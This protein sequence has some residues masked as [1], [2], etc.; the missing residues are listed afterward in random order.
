M[1][2]MF[3][4]HKILANCGNGGIL[5]SIFIEFLV[6]FRRGD[7]RWNIVQAAASHAFPDAAT[8][9]EAEKARD[10]SDRGL[11]ALEAIKAAAPD[12]AVKE[13]EW[14]KFLTDTTTSMK[15]LN[16][17]MGG[18]NTRHQRAL[19]APYVTKFFEEIHG[20]FKSR[21][22]L[23][24]ENFYNILFPFYKIDEETLAKCEGLL[25]TLDV[26][27]DTALVRCVKESID[28]I[29]RELA[30]H[31]VARKHAASHK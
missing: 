27:K 3:E 2:P 26:E 8:R 11:R 23:F 13:A 9:I 4:S 29:K 31:A 18:F 6:V 24:A 17:A 19:L 22:F 14:K 15:M 21:E 25:K 30:C 5:I 16:A 7:M 28:D 1:L 20:I 12:A 10:G